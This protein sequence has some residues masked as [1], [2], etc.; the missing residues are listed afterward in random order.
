MNG[1][2]GLSERLKPRSACTSTK[3]DQILHCL[4]KN[5]SP[6]ENI[7]VDKKGFDKTEFVQDD[8]KLYFASVWRCNFFLNVGQY[9]YCTPFTECLFSISIFTC[10]A[11]CFLVWGNFYPQQ[12]EKYNFRLYH[13]LGLLLHLHIIGS[14]CDSYVCVCVCEMQR[15][16]SAHLSHL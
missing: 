13:R 2:W 6:Q 15:F 5:H 3:S 12:K 11:R 8:L 7:I 1:D 4:L 14:A 10:C 9:N 16:W